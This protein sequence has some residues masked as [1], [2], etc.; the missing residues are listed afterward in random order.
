MRSRS[1]TCASVVADASR[2]S[3]TSASNR[4]DARRQR[5]VH[6]HLGH[7][8]PAQG[9]ASSPIATTGTSPRWSENQGI[10]AAGRRRL[11]LPAACARLR[12]ARPVRDDRPRGDARLLGEGPGQDHAQPP[13]GQA[14][15]LPVGAA[16]LRE[17]LHARH[18]R[19]SGQGAARPGG[20]RSGIKVRQMQASRRR[21]CPPSSRPGSTRPTRRSTRT[22]ARL[23]GGNIRQCVTGAAPIAQ[24]ILE[25]FYACGVP[26]L[27]GYGM[28]E[29]STVATVN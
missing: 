3:S 5:R 29:T 4:S 22:S 12:A 19:G 14:D 21:T 9:R 11:P 13:G 17:D 18:Q 23:F 1:M 26:V 2:P 20:R 27:E 7:H 6:L 10:L 24:E 16:D 8:R 28:T 25:F 15:L